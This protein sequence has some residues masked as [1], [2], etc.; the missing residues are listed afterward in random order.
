MCPSLELLGREGGDT[1]AWQ[2]ESPG[3]S[4][5]KDVNRI[6]KGIES[7]DRVFLLC[8]AIFQIA[9]RLYTCIPTSTYSFSLTKLQAPGSPC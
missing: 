9:D 4:P 3:E 8:F 1:G 2:G 5:L 7:W 6:F